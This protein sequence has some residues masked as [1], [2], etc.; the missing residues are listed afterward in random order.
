MA[1][2]VR[3]GCPELIRRPEGWTAI[4]RTDRRALSEDGRFRTGPPHSAEETPSLTAEGHRRNE[5]RRRRVFRQPSAAR[6]VR[7]A[8]A[9]RSRAVTRRIFSHATV[10]R[11]RRPDTRMPRTKMFAMTGTA[12]LNATIDRVAPHVLGLL[13]DGTPRT[14]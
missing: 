11:R 1:E 13:A 14:K 6:P 8:A 12:E 3:K 10:L 5:N 2:P 4:F 9:R 7:R